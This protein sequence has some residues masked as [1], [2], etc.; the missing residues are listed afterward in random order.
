MVLEITVDSITSM[1]TAIKAG[2]D[3]IEL[4]SAH[5]LGGLTPSYG[6]MKKAKELN[7]ETFIMIRPRAGDFLYDEQEFETMK[8]DILAVK[9]HGI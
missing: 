3:R 4:C 2:A 6:L 1:L 5:S 9:D 8:E 7:I